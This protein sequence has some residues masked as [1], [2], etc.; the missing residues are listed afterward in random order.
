MTGKTLNV[1]VKMRVFIFWYCVGCSVITF[2][3]DFGSFEIYNLL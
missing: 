3:H 1:V 2:I